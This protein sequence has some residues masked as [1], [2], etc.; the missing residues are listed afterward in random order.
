MMAGY[1]DNPETIQNGV[2]DHCRCPRTGLPG[3]H[4]HLSRYGCVYQVVPHTD[5]LE[6]RTVNERLR[7]RFQNQSSTNQ[8]QSIFRNCGCR[9]SLKLLTLNIGRSSDAP[10]MCSEI[11]YSGSCDTHTWS[12]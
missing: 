5:L 6:T 1:V 8:N 4:R 11:L 3:S 7:W 10:C 12:E 9:S 2:R